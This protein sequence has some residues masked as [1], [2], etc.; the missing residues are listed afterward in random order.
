MDQH[1]LAMSVRLSYCR[2]PVRP[3][4][5]PSVSP[6]LTRVSLSIKAIAMKPSQ[7]SYCYCW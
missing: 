2:P 3:P 6:F 4:V 1:H 5:C 7:K